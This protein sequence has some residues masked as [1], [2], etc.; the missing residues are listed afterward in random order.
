MS[1]LL[2]FFVGGGTGALTACGLGGGTLLLIYLVEILDMEQA[3]AQGINLLYF[4]PA[5]IMAMPAHIKGGFIQKNVVVW[6]I[7]GGLLG[8]FLGSFL[9]NWIETALLRKIFG[10]FLVAVGLLNLMQKPQDQEKSSEN[11]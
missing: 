6:G 8:A 10:G 2:A 3:K 7:L 11:S 1:W 5:G 4:L 9:A